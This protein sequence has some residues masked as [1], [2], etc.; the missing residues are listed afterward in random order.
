MTQTIL[1]PQAIS[2]A[3]KLLRAYLRVSHTSARHIRHCAFPLTDC[4]S[5]HNGRYGQLLDVLWME[6]RVSARRV[7]LSL[8]PLKWSYPSERSLKLKKALA[9]GLDALH[10]RLVGTSG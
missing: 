8:M 1:T 2:S 9:E 6:Y 4:L 7:M 5:K 3:N 10:R